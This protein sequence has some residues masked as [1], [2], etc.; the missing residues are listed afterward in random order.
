MNEELLT[1]TAVAFGGVLVVGLAIM[2]VTLATRRILGS[3]T[4]ANRFLALTGRAVALLGSLAVFVY[5][6]F[7]VDKDYFAHMARKDEAF[8]IGEINNLRNRA[9]TLR[10]KSN[11]QADQ[12]EQSIRQLTADIESLTTKLANARQRQSTLDRELDIVQADTSKIQ[13][14]LKEA[15]DDLAT[16]SAEELR[17]TAGY[18]KYRSTES[19][20]PKLVSAGDEEAVSDLDALLDSLDTA[21][22]GG[23]RTIERLASRWDFE[24]SSESSE[25]PSFHGSLLGFSNDLNS[26]TRSMRDLVRRFQTTETRYER[27][28][29]RL[30]ESRASLPEE[31]R[32]TEEQLSS[33]RTKRDNAIVLSKQQVINDQDAQAKLET[34]I[35]R[36]RSGLIGHAVA[37]EPV[38]DL[39]TAAGPDSSIVTSNGGQDSPNGAEENGNPSANGRVD[40]VF[41]NEQTQHFNNMFFVMRALALGAIGAIITLLAKEAITGSASGSSQQRISFFE[42]PDYWPRLVTRTVLGGTIA[43][44]A[45]ALLYTKTISLN[46]MANGGG[47]PDPE[48]WRVTMLCLIS[49]AFSDK[50]YVALASR[51]DNYVKTPGRRSSTKRKPAA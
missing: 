18:E 27:R 42:R 25:S 6:G 24:A 29:K 46:G 45:F 50:L 22:N 39:E 17:F 26:T 35:A 47:L 44:V 19:N 23:R 30:V 28:L 4:A 5:F 9:E 8:K 2:A 3:K 36:L 13:D 16:L 14:D 49:G 34:E 48:F 38:S 40:A 51:V 41:S 43:I 33:Q 31:I 21:V 32:K 12:S 7:F 15:Q 11:L 37:L 20:R 10:R 1:W